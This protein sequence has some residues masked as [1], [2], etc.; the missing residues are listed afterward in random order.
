M[1]A[2]GGMLLLVFAL[3]KAPDQG[4]GSARTIGELVGA[5]GAA[6]RVRRERAASAATRSSRCRSSGSGVSPPPMS[7]MLIAVAGLLSMFFFLTLYMQNVL[8][9][10]A[11][12][13][14]AR[15]TF[16]SPPESA[17]SAGISSQLLAEDRHPADDRRR[18]AGR[19]PAGY[20]SCPGSRP[21]A[22]TS[23]ICCPA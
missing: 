4:W 22:R 14:P 8:G 7:R 12:A 9:L 5:G 20:T 18:R 6:G 21:T 23:P 11:A 16:R 1:L 10:F 2:T 13:G 19:A 17:S 3:V 15:R